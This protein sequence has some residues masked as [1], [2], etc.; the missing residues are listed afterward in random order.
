MDFMVFSIYLASL[1]LHRDP[2]S[3][4]CLFARL[5]Q[6]LKLRQQTTQGSICDAQSTKQEAQLW[7]STSQPKHCAC[8]AQPACVTDTER[9]ELSLA[10]TPTTVVS[11]L[12]HMPCPQMAQHLLMPKQLPVQDLRYQ[13]VATEEE[14]LYV[15][16]ALPRKMPSL[17]QEFLHTNT[18]V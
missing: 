9:R 15:L 13:V 1:S 2:L 7:I 11:Q 10:N 4:Y 18:R 16:Y 5:E 6:F 14:F 12:V 8:P 3:S 17:G